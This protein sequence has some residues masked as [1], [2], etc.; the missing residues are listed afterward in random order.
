MTTAVFSRKATVDDAVMVSDVASKAM[1]ANSSTPST[2]P[3]TSTAP[4]AERRCRQNSA[5][6]TAKAARNRSPSMVKGPM[7]AS[8]TVLNSSDV[9]RA[10]ITAAK[11]NA[12]WDDFTTESFRTAPRPA[13]N[14]L[15]GSDGEGGGQCGS[16]RLP[17]LAPLP[18]LYRGPLYPRFIIA[19]SDSF[20]KMF[21]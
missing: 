13:A 11:S 1:V 19:N 9:E 15:R 14:G 5:T 10:A 3:R 18:S 21:C 12:A 16:S 17:P 8:S 4:P 20:S 6:S 7:S 2:A